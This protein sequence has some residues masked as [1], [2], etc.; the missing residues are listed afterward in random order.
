MPNPSLTPTTKPPYAA[1]DNQEPRKIDPSVRLSD[2][3]PGP[4]N[5]EVPLERTMR[6][7]EAYKP[8]KG[9]VP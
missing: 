4:I 2:P 1:P 3:L 7:P 6:K 8:T 5:G 9:I